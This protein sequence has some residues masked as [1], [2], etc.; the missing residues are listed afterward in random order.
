MDSHICDSC[1]RCFLRKRLWK[2]SGGNCGRW[3]GSHCTCKTPLSFYDIVVVLKLREDLWSMVV[4]FL[5][6]NKSQILPTQTFYFLQTITWG[7]E[8]RWSTKYKSFYDVYSSLYYRADNGRTDLLTIHILEYVTIYVDQIASQIQALI[9]L[10]VRVANK[11]M[12]NSVCIVWKHIYI[13]I[14]SGRNAGSLDLHN[15]FISLRTIY[16]CICYE[17]IQKN[18]YIQRYAYLSQWYKQIQQHNSD[19]RIAKSLGTT[20]LFHQS[21]NRSQ[22][23]SGRKYSTTFLEF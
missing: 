19:P 12:V 2:I 10:V 18:I 9:Y 23:L 13:R 6:T 7:M 22:N 1:Y 17:L 5:C 21:Y 11:S 15:G 14:Q 3:K 4:G 8:L 20:P 16:V